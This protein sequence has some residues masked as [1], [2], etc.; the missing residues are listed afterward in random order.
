MAIKIF[1]DQGHNPRNP[2]AGAEGNGLYEQNITYE[3]GIL[4]AELLN[5]NQNFDVKLSRPTPETSLGSSNSESLAIRAAEANNWG[6]DYF[7]S[8]RA[9]ASTISSA[10]GTEA[11]VYSTTSPAY[12]LAAHITENISEKT[13]LP[14]RGVYV[15]PS[16]YVLRKTVMPA[17]L[18]ELGFITNPIDAELMDKNPNLFAEGIYQGILEY[19]G[20][21]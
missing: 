10:T 15:R 3:V 6:A 19:F 7:I 12:N 13:G 21:S 18:V 20:L 14:N 8:I 9:N 2:N 17:T 5:A 11:F 4:L 16:L 1:I